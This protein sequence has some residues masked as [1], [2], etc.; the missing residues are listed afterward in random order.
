MIT[1]RILLRLRATVLFTCLAVLTS[2]PGWS[3]VATGSLGGVITDPNGA[4]VPTAAV[5]A[6]NVATGGEY[7]TRSSEAGLYIF[8]TLP[9][10]AYEVTVEKA[11][12][13]KLTRSNIEIRV[14]TRQEANL[15][16]EIGD[17]M[18]TVE[19]TADAQLL[20]TTSAQRGQTFSPQLMSNLPLFTGGIRNPRTFV[21]YMPGVNPS[22]ELSVSGSGGRAQEILI[23]GASA[24]IPESGGVSF[25]FPAAEMFGEFKL[26]TSTYD[27]EYGRFGGGI[28]IYVTKSGTTIC[29]GRHSSIC[30]ETSGTRTHG[31]STHPAGRVP[32]SGSTKWAEQSEARFS[33]RSYITERTGRSFTSLIQ[34]TSVP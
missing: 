29:M 23:D 19:V 7:R 32:K 3:Q 20:E 27:A 11:G 18:Q 30:D 8:P 26:L 13:K 2:L 34:K 12:F 17:V 6:K 25:N 14:A 15:K 33:S 1:T 22:A 4:V 31:R 24:T 5:T 16:L 21:N 9:S 28:E 10:G